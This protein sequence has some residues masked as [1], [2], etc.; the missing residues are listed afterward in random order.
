MGII[1]LRGAAIV[2]LFGVVKRSRCHPGLRL[3]PWRRGG[4]NGNR[5]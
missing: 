2:N 1:E 5:S 4:L 3:Q